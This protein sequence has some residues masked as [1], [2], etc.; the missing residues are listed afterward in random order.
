MVRIG[1]FIFPTTL[2]SSDLDI[3]TKVMGPSVDEDSPASPKDGEWPEVEKAE[4]LAR[5]AALKW[6]SG[7]F[8]YPKKLEG[9]GQYHIREK[10]RNI[11][12]QSRIKSTVQSYLEG[13]SMG[14]E[15][16]HSATADVQ[17]VEKE[18]GSV[19]QALASRADIFHSLQQLQEA[20]ER[21][22]QL[23]SVVH[24]LP[25]LFS[26][27]QLLSQAFDFLEGWHLLDAH[28]VL[29]TLESLRDEV[30]SQLHIHKLLNSLHLASVESYFGGLLDLNESLA[31]HLWHVVAHGTRLVSEDPTLF[32]SALRIIEREERADAALLEKAHPLG[33]LPPGRPKCW[34]Q[35]F[36]EV[37]QNT[38]VASL[39]QDIPSNFQSQQFL[40]HL[41][42]MQNSI[43]TE[44]SIVKDHMVQCCPPHYDILTAFASMY[45][46]G[47]ASH[48][49]HILTRDLDKQEI[50]ALLHW[51]IHV[52]PSSEMM[53]HPSLLPEVDVSVFGR[54]LPLDTVEYLEETYL[55]KV[56]ASITEWMQKI[57]EM[58]F[59]EW[60]SEKEPDSD[61]QGCLQTSLPVMVMKMLDE[62][63][64]AVSL[65]SDSLQQKVHK[66]TLGRLEPFLSSLYEKLVEFGKGHQK[67]TTTPKCYT[68]YVLATLNNCLALRTSIAV[69]DRNKTSSLEPTVLPPSLSVALEKVQKKAVKLLLEALL[70][71]LQPLF[72]QLP[73]HQWLTDESQL[74]SSICEVIDKH[75]KEFGRTQTSVSVSEHLVVNQYVGA[76]LQKRMVCRNAEERNQMAR[77]M[78]QDAS[79]L[80]EFFST[81]GLEE[82]K[83]TLKVIV[84]LQELI[85]L[86]DSSMLSLEVLGFMAKYPDVSDDHISILLD[87]RGDITKEIRH[88]V[89]EMVA[90]NLQVLH[91][92]Y[93][94]V[95]SNI[96]VTSP[97][98]PFC[99]G[100]TKCA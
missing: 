93:K 60:L 5:G 31:K 29:M 56:E 72:T 39:F 83:Q 55:G 81:L 25:Q 97:E 13:V 54:L 51:V 65:I 28:A 7:V 67:A 63:I 41:A 18:L 95:F 82:N 8:C 64:R 70:A 22:A 78:V 86:K 1:V 15:W 3:A 47:L 85:N 57:L 11:S 35:R 80:K 46:H 74:M 14:L 69:L 23:G 90:Q 98:P 94:P 50:F 58:E 34:R 30:L 33:Y 16:L 53:A 88:N 73:S 61:Y 48:L 43:L 32:V 24:M 17:Q 84:D 100:K 45:H 77:R 62:N 92:N 91:E 37:V 12:I 52:Y 89:L 68:S 66:M 40:R 76:L 79:W 6:A 71:E 10:Q 44:L 42:S 59:E 27:H 9:L 38:V 2:E 21:H 99:L 36:F 20:A 49:C 4:K 96:L 87:L 26:V 75:T 19:Q